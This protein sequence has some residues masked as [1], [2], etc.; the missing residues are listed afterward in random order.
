M[1][2]KFLAIGLALLLV[3]LVL[4]ACGP[5]GEGCRC[6]EWGGITISSGEWQEMVECDDTVYVP[7]GDETVEISA[8]YLCEPEE[9][10][11]ATYEWEVSSAVAAIDNGSCDTSPCAFDFE[12]PDACVTVSISAYCGD[13][14]CGDC[15]L[16]VCP[17]VEGCGC[18]EWDSI[19]I[20]SASGAWLE[21]VECD[22]PVNVPSVLEVMEISANYMCEP[23][24][25]C[26]TTYEWEISA[27]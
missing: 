16:T 2:Y 8:N 21:T 3:G 12:L 27:P 14:F 26:E 1:R 13:N 5:S 15:T 4:G 10:C 17:P 9:E 25:P 7:S 11:D 23:G 22:V 6:G 18:G 24:Q 19:T 20:S